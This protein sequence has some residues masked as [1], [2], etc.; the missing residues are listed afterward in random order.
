MLDKN[1]QKIF[2]ALRRRND[3]QN[4]ALACLKWT[5]GKGCLPVELKERNA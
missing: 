4:Q 3:E 2:A 1:P 5:L